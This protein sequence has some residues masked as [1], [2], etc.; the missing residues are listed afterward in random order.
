M[1]TERTFLPMKLQLFA[2]GGN[3]AQGGS[4]TQGGTAE[5]NTNGTVAPV[6]QQTGA[7]QNTTQQPEIDY[8]KL[9]AVIQGKQKVT[10]NTVLKSYLKE[11]GLSG[12]ELNKAIQ[13][14]KAQ[15]SKETDNVA[16]IKTQLDQAQEMARQAAETV[17]QAQIEKSA[18]M[19]AVTMGIDA[20]TIPYLLKLADLSGAMDKDG[21][22]D[23][24][25]VQKALN[26]VLEDVPQLKKE[27]QALTGFRVGGTNRQ[28]NG[29]TTAQPQV[30]TKRWNRFN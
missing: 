11:Q 30:A 22:V 5:G 27:E 2:E 12:D 21:K 16:E 23:Q 20:K 4:T 15:K 17:K 19:E 28:Q 26:K 14:Y 29:Q 24:Q 8:E 18:T 1:K 10:E 3:A 6:Q 9:A 13:T 7:Q 25:A